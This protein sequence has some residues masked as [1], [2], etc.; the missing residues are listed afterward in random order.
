VIK[1]KDM[2]MILN[3]NE[4]NEVHILRNINL[5]IKKNELVIINGNNG[6][7]KTSLLSIIGALAKPTSGYIKINQK[8][9]MKFPDKFI[10]NFRLKNI[11]FIFQDFKLLEDFTVY[12]NLLA[13]LIPFGFR[14]NTI[15]EKITKYL[16]MVNMEHKINELVYKLSGGE[17]QRVCI[18]RAIIKEPDI[19]LCDEPTSALDYKNS[20]IFC[21]ILKKIKDSNKT[22]IVATHDNIFQSLDFVDRFINIQDGMI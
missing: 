19:I 15:E 1:I 5:D 9:I 16:N 8:Q 6:S 3:I 2:N 21:K 7:G 14:K 20:L 12:E 13:I 18:A 17:K 11:G 4:R 22:I 10:S